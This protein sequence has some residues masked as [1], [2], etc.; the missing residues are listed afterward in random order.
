MTYFRLIRRF[1]TACFSLMKSSSITD[2]SFATFSFLDSCWCSFIFLKGWHRKYGK[3]TMLIIV[4]EIMV[5]FN[6][7]HSRSCN[8]NLKFP[9]FLFLTNILE[10]FW[11]SNY[12]DNYQD[13]YFQIKYQLEFSNIRAIEWCVKVIFFEKFTRIST[14]V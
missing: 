12:D 10:F 4:G 2:I 13:G 7:N 5:S 9:R 8:F 3:F 1:E 6:K 11:I 14:I